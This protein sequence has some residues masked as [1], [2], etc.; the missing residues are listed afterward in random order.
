MSKR[1]ALKLFVD[2]AMLIL[3]I[4]LMWFYD[5]SPLYHEIA[6]LLI[7]GLFILHLG[8]NR[9]EQSGLIKRIL[10][11]KAS[12]RHIFLLSVDVLLAISMLGAVCTGMLVAH[13]LF[14]GP[15]NADVAWVH[16]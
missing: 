5:T 9:R 8:L 3:Y 2:A 15:G 4:Q 11:R 16:M 1:S 14:Q 7:G 13:E 6:G 10:N 12:F